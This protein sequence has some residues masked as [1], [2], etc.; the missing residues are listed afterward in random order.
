MSRDFIDEDLL[1][2]RRGGESGGEL[3]ARS[4]S[5]ISREGMAR[6]S[7]QKSELNHHVADAVH[8]IEELRQRQEQ[9]ERE[10]RELEELGRKQDEY[11]ANKKEVIEQL[12]ASIMLLEK[13][14]MQAAR[15]LELFG[16]LRNRF[17]DS[18]VELRAISENDWN[19][20]A[21]QMELNKAIVIVEEARNTFRKGMAKMEAAGWSRGSADGAVGSPD[22]AAKIRARSFRHW[23]NIGFAVSIPVIVFVTLL[24]VL[25]LYLSGMFG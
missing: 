16:V 18:L 4:E 11:A 20:E 23:M 12:T 24:F 21:Y 14:E 5:A 1:K 10:K 13:E 22:V 15:L 25:W 9:L 8:E 6:L 17:K 3:S 2:I 7:H 19:E